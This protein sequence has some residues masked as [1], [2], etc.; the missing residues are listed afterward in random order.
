MIMRTAFAATMLGALAL[1]G[2]A[3][4][5]AQAAG[6]APQAI[7]AAERQSGATADPQLTAE[8][9]GAYAGPQS[10]L[11][12][13]VGLKVARQSGI[14]G[15][16]REFSFKLL[17]SPVP[18]A[19]AVPGGYVYATRG[20][21][22]LMNTESELAFVLGH[23]AGHIAARHAQKREKVTQRSVLLG[24]LGQAVLGAVLGNGALG[25]VGG[26]LGQAGIQRLVVGTVMSHSRAE[27][28]EADDLGVGYAAQA[29]YDP[30]ASGDILGA[31]AAQSALEARAEGA[32]R[33]TPS[34][35]MSHP[36]PAA[37]VVRARQRA[38]AQATRPAPR[39]SD[40]F[41]AGLDGLL[42]GD[43]PA[44]GLIEGQTF[45]YPADRI[46]F[47][48]PA[49][50]GM[51]NGTDA[52]T[53]TPTA[54]GGAGQARFSGGKFDGNLDGLVARAFAALTSAAN[55]NSNS[56]TNASSGPASVPTTRTTVGG[57][58]ARTATVAAADG[59]GTP[60]DVTVTAIAATPA[61]AYA[62]AVVQP[63][64]RGMGDLAPLV[65]SF[66]RMSEAEAAAVRP[67][68]LKVVAAARGD[69]VA[70]LS[71]RM[72]YD[73]LQAE[74]FLVLNNL[75]AG[76]TAIAPGRKVKLV[77]WGAPARR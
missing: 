75:P 21:L 30:A 24:T 33:T 56:N 12:R 67:R 13:Q 17:N 25:Q 54:G 68:V 31:L 32:S 26:S 37:R 47:T 6:Q 58:D 22:A 38:S 62:F 39:A 35:A 8:Y 55:A 20:L 34:W 65:S 44:Q 36:D 28:F 64:G 45:R 57:L 9:G 23:E 19:F 53:I 4:L 49:G 71:R 27:E 74:R 40:A 5:L 52:V 50:Y 15:A 72:A 18:N 1:A 14:P 77:V 60:I 10:A 7:S 51:A 16:E 42:Y 69:T 41:L 70:T 61:T 63:R 48:A 76:T 2:P 59:N 3:P 73:S 66:R 46:A 43:D 29:G 11:V